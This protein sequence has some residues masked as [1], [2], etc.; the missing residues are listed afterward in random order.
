MK[1]AVLD[2]R[3]MYRHSMVCNGMMTYSQLCLSCAKHSA[4]SVLCPETPAANIVTL[5]SD[6]LLADLQ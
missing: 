3:R 1:T 4:V 2:A 5:S 6:I